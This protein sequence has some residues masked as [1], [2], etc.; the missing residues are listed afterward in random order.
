MYTDEIIWNAI[1]PAVI[2]IGYILLALVGI[3]I[4]IAIIYYC[5]KVIAFFVAIG[6][7]FGLG[8]VFYTYLF[9]GLINFSP[10]FSG[11]LSTLL[12]IG[13]VI[14]FI[15]SVKGSSS[16]GNSSGSGG[17]WGMS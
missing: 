11:V 8:W 7:T 13:I 16:S 15:G 4:L 10:I 2:V 12:V 14:G 17:D 9:R 3:A 6:L 5:W 1:G